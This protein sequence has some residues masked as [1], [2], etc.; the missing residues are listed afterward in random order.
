ME[1]KARR[2]VRKREGYGGSQGKNVADPGAWL[3]SFVGCH[4]AIC[5]LPRLVSTAGLEPARQLA[6]GF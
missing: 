5:D 3:I 1:G 6:G 4:I 2:R